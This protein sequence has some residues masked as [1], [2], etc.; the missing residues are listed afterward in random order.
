MT[1]SVSAAP[2]KASRLRF[3]LREALEADE[4]K[5]T[6]GIVTVEKWLVVAMGVP[7]TPFNGSRGRPDSEHVRRGS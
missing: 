1:F 6:A 7:P 2:D 4:F 5:L 3:V